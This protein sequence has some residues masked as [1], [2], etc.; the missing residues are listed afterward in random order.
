M[1]SLKALTFVAMFGQ[2]LVTS[3]NVPS[4]MSI[5]YQSKNRNFNKLAHSK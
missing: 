4:P 1:V 3:Y 5:M 2:D